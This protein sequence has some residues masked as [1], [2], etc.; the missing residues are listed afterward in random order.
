MYYCFVYICFCAVRYYNNETFSINETAKILKEIK[1]FLLNYA[2]L[3]SSLDITEIPNSIQLCHNVNINKMISLL[4][5][6][7]Y[8]ISTEIS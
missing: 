1:T 3:Y 6:V 2:N 4:S 8:R 7:G 5:S